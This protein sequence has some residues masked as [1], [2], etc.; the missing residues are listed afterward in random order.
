MIRNSVKSHSIKCCESST[1]VALGRECSY[2]ELVLLPGVFASPAH[3][4]AKILFY[5]VWSP[6]THG[7][8]TTEPGFIVLQSTIKDPHIFP[9]FWE[10]N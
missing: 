1:L 5:M 2:P 7:I 4:S 9:K 10:K 8:L 6:P 3:V